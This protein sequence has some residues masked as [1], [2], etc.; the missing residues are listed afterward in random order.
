MRL[1]V[2]LLTREKQLPAEIQ[3]ARTI[4]RHVALFAASADDPSLQKSLGFS[5][6]IWRIR[7]GGEMSK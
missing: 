5:R 3:K 7:I 2:V 6:Y 1:G 4:K